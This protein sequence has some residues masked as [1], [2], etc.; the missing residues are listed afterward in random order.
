VFV[1]KVLSRFASPAGFALVLLLFFLMPF[2][3]VSCDDIDVRYTGSH[4]VSGADPEV[5]AELKEFAE[6]AEA[7]ATLVEPPDPGAQVLAIVLVVLAVGGMATAVFTR[8]RTRLLGAAV[9]AGATLVVTI[10]T[11][12]V[13]RSSIE[14]A[15]FDR[16]RETAVAD[17]DPALLESRIGELIHTEVGF[18]L[19]VVLLVL[20]AAVTA[21]LGL[22][23]DRLRLVRADQHTE[24]GGLLSFGK[25]DT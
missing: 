1:K 20:I 12:V 9:A 21:L 5:P 3:A 2:M 7:P 17:D 14:S 6:D 24:D 19:M 13:A 25:D 16:M 23:G 22:F 8:A 4:L 10:V 11:M 15:L 18:W